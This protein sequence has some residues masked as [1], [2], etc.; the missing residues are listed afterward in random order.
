VLILKEDKALCFDAL[1]QVLILKEL[2]MP[3]RGAVD[4]AHI[5]FYQDNYLPVNT[6]I[7]DPF[8]EG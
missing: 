7:S 5:L 1:L 6:K 3:V 8:G 2:E 4:K